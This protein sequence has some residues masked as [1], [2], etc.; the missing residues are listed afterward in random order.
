[1]LLNNA[2][3]LKFGLFEQINLSDHLRIVDVNINGCL[4]CIYHSLPYLKKT[5]GARI[6][7]LS[8]IS[9]LYGIPELAVYSSTKHALSAMTE[10]LNI[11]LEPYGIHVCDIKPPYVSTPMLHGGENVKSMK[12]IRFLGGQIKT[13][14][15]TGTIWK[16]AQKNRL[17]WNIGLTWAHGFSIFSL[18][19]Y[20]TVFRET[21]NHA[22]S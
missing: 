16:A 10:A 1:M 12:A 7:N 11:E 15:V 17:H 5:P 4:R 14:K 2:G 6:I 8:S 9:S 22:E 21:A 3:I 20:Q 19:L 13:E 18:A